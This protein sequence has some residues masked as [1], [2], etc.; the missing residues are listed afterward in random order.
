MIIPQLSYYDISGAYVLGTNLWHSENFIQLAGD[1]SQKAIL[2]D[3]FFA[4]SKNFRVRSFVDE[5]QATYGHPPGFIEAVAYDTAMLLMEILARNNV[6]YRSQL[7][8]ALTQ[9]TDF[10]GITGKTSFDQTGEAQKST[11]V[12]CIRNKR[13]FELKQP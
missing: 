7:K 4:G 10:P 9:V 11:Y 13:F 8:D 3:G 12:L 6:L 1:Y 2:T 5:F